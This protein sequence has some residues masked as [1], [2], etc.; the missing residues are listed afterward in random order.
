MIA[1][2]RCGLEQMRNLGWN[3]L[4]VDDAIGLVWAEI[5]THLFYWFLFPW[6]ELVV[7]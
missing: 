1:G 4:L 6:V 5:I 2:L 7:S 3:E